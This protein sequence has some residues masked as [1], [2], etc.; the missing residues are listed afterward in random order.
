MA[1]STSPSVPTLPPS[2]E[3]AYRRKCVFLKQRMADVEE[4]NDAVRVRLARLKRQVEKQRLER[5]FLLEQLAKRTSTN[6][7]DSDGSPSPPATPKDKPLR[8]KRGHRKTSIADGSGPGSTFISQNLDPLS[9]SSDVFSKGDS[10]TQ[11]TQ[12][13]PAA[14]QRRGG[15][16]S[17]AAKEAEEAV[18]GKDKEDGDDDKVTAGAKRPGN[19]FELYCEEMRPTL[20]E[21]RKANKKKTKSGEDGDDVDMEDAD[22]EA[23]EE[24]EEDEAAVES[25]IDAELARGWTEMEQGEKEEFEARAAEEQAK[26]KKA[27]EEA[28]QQK[29][30]EKEEKAE[31]EAEE[32]AK[33]KDKEDDK[34]AGEDDK[35]EAAD[36]NAVEK[37]AADEDKADKE[38]PK[39]VDDKPEDKDAEPVAKEASPAKEAEDTEMADP[40]SV[41]VATSSGDKDE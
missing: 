21:K 28:R 27:K 34:P 15:R 1:P 36:K 8:T 40:D 13:T 11:P 3:E 14:S 39:D 37:E 7:E 12:S 4:A 26:Y 22:A 41:A 19:A 17:K 23:G 31:K 9:P 33:A 6:V 29:E 20:V 32:E 38:A 10:Q 5:A 2:V 30:K 24:E 18:N 25:N 35:A 16:K